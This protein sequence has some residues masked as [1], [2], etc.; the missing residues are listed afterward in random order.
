MCVQAC[1]RFVYHL[2]MM[3]SI[4]F[5]L[6]MTISVSANKSV[7]VCALQTVKTDVYFIDVAQSG[8][9]F[10]VCRPAIG[11]FING[12]HRSTACPRS[13]FCVNM[14]ES[15]SPSF[16]FYKCIG[17]TKVCIAFVAVVACSFSK[18]AK[19]VKINMCAAAIHA[20]VSADSILQAQNRIWFTAV[21]A[22]AAQTPHIHS[23]PTCV[24]VFKV[25][26]SRAAQIHIARSTLYAE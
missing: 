22:N 24:H 2:I 5:L 8:L 4:W 3:F 15:L 10:F 19:L 26:L 11:T 9:S 7:S 16:Q 1:A 25:K 14:C 20:S 23:I 6:G 12:L 18:S 21:V 13:I 17:Q